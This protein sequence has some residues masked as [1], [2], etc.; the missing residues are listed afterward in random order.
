M[1]LSSPSHIE[2]DELTDLPTMMYFRHHAGAYVKR[3]HLFGHRA[4]LIYFNLENFSGFNERYGFE[5]GDK[6]LVLMSLAI[7]FAFPGFLLSR[8]S[9]DHF[10]LVCESLHP[11]EAIME[12]RDQLVAFSRHARVELKAGIFAIDAETIDIG[13]ACDRAKLACDSIS[14]RYDTTFRWYDENLNW[15]VE[16]KKYIV[17]HIDQAVQNEWIEVYYQPIVRSLTG[18]VC[19]F[20]AL[21]RWDDPKYGFLSPGVFVSVLEESHLIHKLDAFVVRKA[22]EEWAQLKNAYAW[23]IPI[24]VNLSRLDFELCDPF[25]MVEAASHEFDVPRQMIHVEI[26][27][28]A[29]NENSALLNRQIERFRKAGYQVWLDDFGSGYSS[30]NT[31]KDFVFDVVKI[32]M[33]FLREFEHRPKSR[34]IIASMVNM[35]KQLGMQTLIEGVETPAQFDFLRDIGC[36]LVQGYL[37]GKPSPTAVNTRRIQNGELVL[38]HSDL[39]G[40]YNRL[41][42]INSLSATPFEFPWDS[43]VKERTFAEMLP[44]A[45]L[46]ED[47]DEYHFVSS[48]DAFLRV[49]KGLHMGNMTSI[50]QEMSEGSSKHGRA[51]RGAIRTAT[52]SN[53]LESIDIIEEGFHCVFRVRRIAS[54]DNVKAFLVSIMDMSRFAGM[55][56]DNRLQSA[57]HNLHKVYDEIN[58]VSLNDMAASTIF[59]GNTFFPSVPDGTKVSEVMQLF[60]DRYLHPQDRERYL[61]YMELDS[62][63]SRLE[64][65]G[66]EY[67]AEAFRALM[68]DG[69]YAWMTIVLVPIMMDERRMVLVCSRRSNSDAHIA[70]SNEEEIP[71]SLLWDTLVDL[72]PAGVF[73]KNA[74]RRFVGVNKNFLDFYAFE[75]TNDVLG[76]TDE[77]MGWHVDTDPFKNNELRVLAGE[78]VL[79]AHGT[80]IAQ[81][82]VRNIL[83]SKIPLRQGGRVIGL[84]GYFTDRVQGTGPSDSLML[85]GF[86]RLSETDQLTGIPNLRGLASSAVSYQDSYMGGG[87]NFMCAVA[88]IVD[89][90]N[91]NQVY[92]RSFGNRIIKVVARVITKAW[93]VDGVVARIGGDEFAAIRQVENSAM[94]I[95]GVSR[96]QSVVEQVKD[97]DGVVVQLRCNIGYAL[98]SETND[99]DEALEVARSRMRESAQ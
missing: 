59:R 14:G 89:L 53:N 63:E 84:L 34:V 12:A 96:I 83:A 4:Y 16:R 73:W 3:A 98:F 58:V 28:S 44:L 61:R 76:K 65:S 91:F 5:E 48:N 18:E 57:L 80:C 70:M 40:Y 1:P 15:Y 32:D 33:A 78:S 35:A 10:L 66:K 77:D 11:E 49:L 47:L 39:H 71:K 82:E 38:E 75:S 46:E 24:S 20:E 90:N 79:N 55:A 43:G 85:D 42:S 6:L 7:Q 13:V 37:I 36:E 93:G 81:G 41:G 8:F 62:I 45:I 31:L 51:M 9:G 26:T 72:V 54:H 30:L 22:C 29:L 52:L 64:T 67:L 60:I 87:P 69:L 17:S 56:G 86:N 97:V 50:A 95:E 88:E 2:F 92:G 23:R 19:E 21:A 74:D 27:E 25:E 94:A 99:I 68:P